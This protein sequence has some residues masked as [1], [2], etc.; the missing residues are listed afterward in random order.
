LCVVE[1]LNSSPVL[2]DENFFEITI[3]IKKINEKISTQKQ[4]IY[5]SSK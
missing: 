4:T 5:T 2:I 1:K 3:L